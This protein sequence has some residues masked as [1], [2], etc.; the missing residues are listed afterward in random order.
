MIKAKGQ[1]TPGPRKFQDGALYVVG[2]HPK[3]G[4]ATIVVTEPN[5]PEPTRNANGHL[6]AAA[7]DLLAACE[8]AKAWMGPQSITEGGTEVF[9]MLRDA[10]VSAKGG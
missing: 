10:I 8:E 9:V 1:H 5:G 6:I 4:G 7:P 3:T 2:P